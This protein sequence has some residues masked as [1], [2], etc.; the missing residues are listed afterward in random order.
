VTIREEDF[1]MFTQDD[2]INIIGSEN[3]KLY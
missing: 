3:I 1:K 2:F